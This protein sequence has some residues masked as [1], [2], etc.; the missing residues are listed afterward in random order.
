MCFRQQ[1]YPKEELTDWQRWHWSRRANIRWHKRSCAHGT[2]TRQK[3]CEE[4]AEFEA[5]AGQ[6]S[7]RRAQIGERLSR[8]QPGSLSRSQDVQA[9]RKRRRSFTVRQRRW[10]NQGR[11]TAVFLQRVEKLLGVIAVADVIKEDS[12][13]ASP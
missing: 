5:V 11:N 8:R 12:P 10:Q 13:R 9:D 3:T 4:V 7:D 1:V 6:R 2:G